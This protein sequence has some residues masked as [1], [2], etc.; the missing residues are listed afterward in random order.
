MHKTTLHL[1][2]ELKREIDTAAR[3]LDISRSEF[4]RRATR[5]YLTDSD[6]SCIMNKKLD[7]S[8]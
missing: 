3:I 8:I 5:W 6:I 4:M 2:E 7:S 1:P